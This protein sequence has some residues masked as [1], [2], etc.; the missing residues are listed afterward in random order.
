MPGETTACVGCHEHRTDAVQSV[1]VAALSAM[2]RRPRRIKPISD[3]PEVFDF[4]RD[5]KPI[6]DRHCVE[7]HGA[8]R[9]DGGVTLSGNRG[10]RY[11]LAYA[12]LLSRPGLVSHGRDADGNKA[13]RGIGS[14]ASRL[15][16]LLDGSHFDAQL[17]PHEVKMIRLWIDSGAV[18]A[19]TY[20]ALGTGMA[21]VSFPGDVF[22]KRCAVC[23]QKSPPGQQELLYDL[24]NAEQSLVLLAPLAKEAGGLGLCRT[25]FKD[26]DASPGNVFTSKNDADFQKAVNEIARAGERLDQQKRFDMPGFRPSRHYIREMIRFDVLSETFDAEVDP[27]DVYETDRR[28]WRSLW[29]AP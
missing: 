20:A 19:G 21:S 25:S 16:Q 1:D 3:V 9:T 12:T 22:T 17:S 15:M 23:H 13:A 2:R 24:T 26:K 10:T 8:Q 7:C 28:Y 4:P 27:V 6:L 29:H 5:I 18:Y 11:S 14:S